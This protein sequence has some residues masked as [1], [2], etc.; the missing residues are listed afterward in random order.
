MDKEKK[1]LKGLEGLS[2][3]IDIVG[4]LKK[5]EKVKNYVLC[6]DCKGSG[7]EEGTMGM[8]KTC[9]GYGFLKKTKIGDK[10]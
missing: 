8:C 4:A 1:V 6:S 3:T 10:K 2:S 7:F 5:G 9:Y